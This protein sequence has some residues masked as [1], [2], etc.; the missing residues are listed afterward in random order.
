M[1][2][3]RRPATA[4]PF[5]PRTVEL[6]LS[7]DPYLSAPD[8]IEYVT[9]SFKVLGPAA[10][11]RIRAARPAELAQA[12]LIQAA[13]RDAA[14]ARYHDK[15]RLVG[16]ISPRAEVP[17]DETL[18]DWLDRMTPADRAQAEEIIARVGPTGNFP[19][20]DTAIVELARLYRIEHFTGVFTTTNTNPDVAKLADLL[21]DLCELRRAALT[22]LPEWGL[23]VTADEAAA[24]LDD[25]KERY[26]A[27]PAA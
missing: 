21:I 17:L 8:G 24:A 4:Q 16:L 3:T 15:V 14:L 12:R 9:R 23:S 10:T 11:K 20:D 18:G 5:N 25:L 13:R 1:T 26:P 22:G 7:V 19:D 27:Q 6:L 2:S